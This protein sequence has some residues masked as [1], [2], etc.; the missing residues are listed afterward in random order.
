MSLPIAVYSLSVKG[1]DVPAVEES[2][3]A[4]IHLTMASIDA[5][6]KS[7]KPTTLLVKVRPRIPVE[8]EDDEELDEQMQELLEESQREFVLCT[9]KPG[10]LYQ[11]PLNLTITPGDEVFFSASGDAT[12]HLSGNFLVDEEDEEEEESDED[13]DLSPTEED[14][15]ETVSGDEESEEE[16]ESEDNSASEED[17]LDSA[18]AKKAQVKKKRT[19][20]ESE[21]EEAASPKKNNTKK[22]KVEGTPVKE[23]KVA[24]AEKL[25]QGPTGPAAK[26]E[27]Q[28][29]S[30]NAPSSPKTR[31]LKGG[32]VVTDVKTGS[33]ASATN[34]KK[35]EMRYIGKLE[36]GKVFDKN[37]KGKPFAFILGRGE[38][39]RGWDVGVA[40][41]QEGGERKITIP[42]PMAYGNQSIPGI[43]KN[44]TLVFEVKLVRVH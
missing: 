36:N 31:T 11:Q 15:V 4:S 1:K 12:I 21:Q 28:Q 33:G 6:E 23:K 30:S 38:V 27:K 41:M 44:S 3:D 25:E 34:G 17:E 24:F 19:K 42:A 7:N 37:T 16:S 10:S 20:D 40:G 8:D 39:I 2:T 5:G 18:P 26:K 22:Q 29:A 43:P 13:Y 35:V 9:L 32:V 14:L